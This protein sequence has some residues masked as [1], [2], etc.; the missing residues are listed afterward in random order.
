MM[1][2]SHERIQHAFDLRAA[3]ADPEH[4]RKHIQDLTPKPEP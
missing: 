4:F 1:A 2:A 3:A